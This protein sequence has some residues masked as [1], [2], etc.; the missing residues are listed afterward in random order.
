MKKCLIFICVLVLLSGCTHRDVDISPLPE[1]SS[2]IEVTPSSVPSPTPDHPG[3]SPT[4]D[5]FPP[6]TGEMFEL[7]G[8]DKVLY[9]AAVD[10]RFLP[11]SVH[12]LLPELSIIGS[13]P[14]EDE[15]THYVCWLWSF[16]YYALGNGLEDLDNPSYALNTSCGPVR[17]TIKENSSQE[18]ECVEFMEA[19]GDGS[20]IAW[21]LSY[22]AICGPYKEWAEKMK[23]ATTRYPIDLS[24]EP[25][26]L[27]TTDP[28]EMLNIYLNYFFIN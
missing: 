22:D 20:D 8:I 16:D 13:Y 2:S 26:N 7:S 25:R 18:F 24:V 23:N 12:L 19:T 11:G 27:T 17:V 21:D 3:P 10:Q 28:V 4:F 1:V 9:E 6:P 15:M 14:G 5:Q